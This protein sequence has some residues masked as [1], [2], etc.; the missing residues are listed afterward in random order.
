MAGEILTL[1]TQV[2]EFLVRRRVLG[3][4]VSRA[5]NLEG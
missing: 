4:L 1:L 5:Q 3:E 2:G